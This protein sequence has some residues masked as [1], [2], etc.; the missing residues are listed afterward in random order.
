MVM[1]HLISLIIAP[2]SLTIDRAIIVFDTPP[3]GHSVVPLTVIVPMRK[4]YLTNCSTVLSENDSYCSGAHI[5]EGN[6]TGLRSVY[7]DPSNCQGVQYQLFG[8]QCASITDLPAG[9]APVTT[10]AITDQVADH[11]NT[12]GRYIKQLPRPINVHAISNILQLAASVLVVS[13]SVCGVLIAVIGLAAC[14][15]LCIGYKH[16]RMKE[17]D[18]ARME[19]I[20]DLED[21]HIS[22]MSFSG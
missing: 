9:T 15:G 4:L 13:L 20:K 2:V 14:V 1:W 19:I 11:S 12:Y 5:V 22:S 21:R 6:N 17:M 18:K 8:L 16:M 10:I 3:E 7:L